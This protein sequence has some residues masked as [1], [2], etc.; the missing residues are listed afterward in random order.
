MICFCLD[1]NVFIQAKN[2]ILP[3]HVLRFSPF[4]MSAQEEAEVIRVAP[5]IA[6]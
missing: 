5:A 4:R 6:R 3:I 1:T 2:G